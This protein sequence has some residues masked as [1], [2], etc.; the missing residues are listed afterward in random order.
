MTKQIVS[1]LKRRWKK[2]LNRRSTT[3]MIKKRQLVE[4]NRPEEKR[5]SAK[6]IAAIQ[7]MVIKSVT[8]AV[9]AAGATAFKQL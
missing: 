9:T 1:R 7:P 8:T 5:K 3:K 2:R 6:M 4:K